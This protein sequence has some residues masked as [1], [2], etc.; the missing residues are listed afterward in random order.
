MVVFSPVRSCQVFFWSAVRPLTILATLSPRMVCI[1]FRASAC[2]SGSMPADC[3]RSRMSSCRPFSSSLTS[4]F[5]LSVSFS[6]LSTSST[7]N[8]ARPD[9]C[10]CSCL[11]R[12]ICSGLRTAA[13]AFSWSAA[14]ALRSSACFSRSP[15]AAS[16]W[17]RYLGAD[18]VG[19]LLDVGLLVIG[20][21]Q[22]VLHVLVVEEPIEAGRPVAAEAAAAGR[23][24]ESGGGRQHE[25]AGGQEVDVHATHLPTPRNGEKGALRVNELNTAPAAGTHARPG[26]NDTV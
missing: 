23:L 14:S 20:D 5:C 24:C 6:A 12:F 3:I 8:A 18:R 1:F 26:R 9:S 4:S 21:F 15:R 17:S 10:T 19:G 2:L 7:E 11:A 16:N 25:Q 22:L 13:R